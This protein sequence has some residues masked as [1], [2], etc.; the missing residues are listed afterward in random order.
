M[1][2]SDWS[3]DV[4]SSDLIEADLAVRL[5]VDLLDHLG[6]RAVGRLV[7]L[8]RHLLGTLDQGAETEGLRGAEAQAGA[9]RPGLQRPEQG[10]GGRP[11][12][13]P[14]PQPAS[15]IGSASCGV[16]VCQIVSIAVVAV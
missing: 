6:R 14:L 7:G 16:R 11:G 2:I 13:G 10:R 15:E 12:G 1:R 4:C 8:A 3:S 9:L 5:V